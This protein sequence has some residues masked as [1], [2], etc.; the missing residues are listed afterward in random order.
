MSYPKPGMA[1]KVPTHQLVVLVHSPSVGPRVWEPVARELRNHDCD[2]VMPS[3]LRVADAPPPFWPAVVDGVRDA[4]DGVGPNPLALVMHSN[5]GCFA[6][7]LVDTLQQPV[8]AL[9]FVDAG[10]PASSGTTSLVP[11]EFMVFLREKA[12]DGMLPPWTQWWDEHDVAP[13]FPDD[14]TRAE[15]QAEEPHLPLA[16]Y[17][18]SIPVTSRWDGRRC[19]YLKFSEGYEDAAAEAR[20]RGWQVAELPGQH[21]HMLVDPVNTARLILELSYS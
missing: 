8:D 7:V 3:L 1:F 18:Q 6:P 5:A 19:A 21:L 10:I 16:Y 13:L 20:R 11:D 12:V 17:E 4:L 2:V 14:Q 9:I 15:V